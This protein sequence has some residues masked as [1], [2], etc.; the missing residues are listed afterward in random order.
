M[1]YPKYVGGA[2]VAIKEI[3][4]RID[5]SDIQFHLI[6]LNFD[7]SD[8]KEEQIGNVTVHRVGIGSAYLSK[9]LFVPLAAWKA[10]TLHHKERFD[11]MWAMMSY[12]LFPLV[13]AR[14]F[15]VRIPYVLTLQ[16]GDTFEKVYKRW[17]ILPFLPLLRFGF[18]NAIVVQ[19]ISNFL[20]EWPRRHGFEGP[21]EVVY[22]GANAKD[23]TEVF[24]KEELV[25]FKQKVGKKDGDV[26]IVTTSRLVHKNATDDVIRAMPMLPANVYFIVVGGGEDEA[27]LKQLAKDLNVSERVKFVGQVSREETPKYRR[28]A[29]IFARP[30]RSEGMGN[31]FVSAM[32]ARLPI[33]T[34]QEGGIADFLFDAKRNP[35]KPTTGWAVDKD[36]PEQIALAVKDI[37][38]DPDK[39]K[40]VTD[41]AYALAVEKYNWNSIAKDMRSKVFDQVC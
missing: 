31:S 30:S 15:G 12:M 3:T 32:A 40:R 17:F 19:V 13:F 27:M 41:T 1:H 4:D 5:S 25:A 24:T 29:D 23:F 20:A 11:G 9:M 8:P 39:V 26:Y 6:T 28:I 33:V 36:S 21:V 35:D 38:A 7:P 10:A 14:F 2:E 16:E 18:R 37:L 34:T 22:N